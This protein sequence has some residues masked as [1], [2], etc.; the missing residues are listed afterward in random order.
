MN[1]SEFYKT[2]FMKKSILAVL[3]LLTST[4][5]YSQSGESEDKKQSTMYI[6]LGGLGSSFQ[7]IKF[8]NVHY[9]G[10]GLSLDFGFEK[11]K[12]NLWGVNLNLIAS[13]GNAKTHDQ[14]TTLMLNGII[15]A[16]YLVPVLHRNKS[17]LYIGGTWDVIDLYFRE[18]IALDNNSITYVSNSGI[19]GSGMYEKT[20]SS[21]MKLEA[22]LDFQLF[23]FVKEAPGFAINENQEALERGK[24]GYQDM[25]I[26]LPTRLDYYNLEPF[27]DYVNVKTTIKL[28]YQKRWVFTYKWNIQRS[29]RI[30]NYPLTKG[31]NTLSI[32]YNIIKK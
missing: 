9:N 14:G 1:H 27:W 32:R 15:S 5:A 26:L 19:K 30:D 31:Y 8:S 7:D 6:G 28:H 12:K 18:A 11:K 10:A 2:P 13:V 3:V 21:K 29:H 20:L 4:L 17:N 24:F 23:G 22:G 16:K 25:G